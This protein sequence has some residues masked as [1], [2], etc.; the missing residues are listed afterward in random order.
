M[1]Y[2]FKHKFCEENL[3]GLD[4]FRFLLS[5][6]ILIV[7]FPHFIYPFQSINSFDLSQLPFYTYLSKIYINGG[8]AVQ[9][10]WMLSGVIFS[11]FY[12]YKIENLSFKNYL[13]L[14]LSR[15]YP[16][17]ILT[18]FLVLILQLI[19][20]KLN[21]NFF[22]INNN[23][24]FHFI[25]NILLI[26][27]W[28]SDFQLSFNAPFWSVSVE[29][30]SYIIFYIFISSGLLKK[31][32]SLLILIFSLILFTSIKILLPF[33]ECLLYFFIGVMFV[34]KYETFTFSKLIA[35]ITILIILLFLKKFIFFNN[36]FIV[37]LIILFS[38]LIFSILI[39]FLFSI[40][41]YGMSNKIKTFIRKL[42]GLTYS[43]YMIHFPLQLI[44]ILLFKN[45]GILFFNNKLFF[46]SYIV[47]SIVIAYFI[48][49]IYEIPLQNYLRKK[50][51]HK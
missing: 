19:Y 13:I 51:I 17:H 23:D 30:F 4:I 36:I 31:E 20:H 2:P 6:S 49:S 46:S 15:L 44:L 11:H 28:N 41:V 9:L 48:Y 35:S 34:R 21:S 37:K 27:Y 29:I 8:F 12:F 38:S 22:I 1:N 47:I 5:I 24:T 43:M 50:F 10:F 32:K 16:L 26:N 40:K 18:L 33:N 25:L 3:I 45:K 39:I 7:H 42:S 14:R